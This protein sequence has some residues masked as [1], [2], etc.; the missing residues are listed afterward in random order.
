[1]PRLRCDARVCR[2]WWLAAVAGPNTEFLPFLSDDALVGGLAIEQRCRVL[3]VPVY[4]FC[5]G[6]PL[7][8]DHLDR[9]WCCLTR[10][11]PEATAS[12]EIRDFLTSR[13]A[14]IT[15]DQDAAR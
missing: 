9:T 5:G 4:R 1:L 8:P 3:G 15:P 11:C 7:C 12:D 13:R 10:R 2:S 6:G 14:R